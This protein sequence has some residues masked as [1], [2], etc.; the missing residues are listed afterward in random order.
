MGDRPCGAPRQRRADQPADEKAHRRGAFHRA[1]GRLPDRP[2]AVESTPD[3]T[4]NDAVR[5]EGEFITGS[6]REYY[7]RVSHFGPDAGIDVQGEVLGWLRMPQPLWSLCQRQLGDRAA[8]PRNARAGARRGARGARCR[9]R[10][11]ALRRAGRTHGHGAVRRACRPGRRG[12]GDRG[13]IWSHKWIVPGGM[14][15]GSRPARADLPHRAGG[16]RGRVSARMSGAIWRRAGPTTT[17]PARAR[18]SPA[19]ASA[20]TA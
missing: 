9:R 18:T 13:D 5:L 12:T 20:C 2:H 16:L 4:A 7:R 8:T 10:L 17:T 1:A 15:V 6:M 11:R 14:P 19:T 3:A